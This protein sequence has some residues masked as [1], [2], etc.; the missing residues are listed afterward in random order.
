MGSTVEGA[1]GGVDTA[2][3]N[4]GAASAAP[5]TVDVAVV[6]MNAVPPAGVTDPPDSEV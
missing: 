6:G 4:V 3:G 5:G 2:A 1:S